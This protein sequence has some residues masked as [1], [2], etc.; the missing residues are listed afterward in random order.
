M[1]RRLSEG[2][3]EKAPEKVFR[4]SATHPDAAA[5]DAAVEALRAGGL[6]LF[7][8][9]TVYSIGS[10]AR[11]GGAVSPGVDRLF[12]LK[13]RGR[14]PSFP[15]LV[16]SAA[17]LTVY[18]TGVTDDARTLA[19][20]FWPGELSIVV[21]ASAAIPRVLAREDGTVALRVSAS[22]VVA[23]IVEACDAPLVSTGAN[24]H[25]SLPPLSFDEVSKDILDKVD[26]ALDA[27]A[28]QCVGPATIVD[29]TAYATRVLRAGSISRWSIDNAIGVE[30]ELV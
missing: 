15:W 18:G 27:G 29:C 20:S 23:A 17:D 21:R 14:G 11:A 7:P 10:L 16:R 1:A 13:H 22:P 4:I 2:A 26:V 24:I 5:I 19:E 9:D 12:A 3:S 30:T 8:T 6:V 28:A 25:G